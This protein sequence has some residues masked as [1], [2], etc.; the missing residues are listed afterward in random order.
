M[1]KQKY[2]S[3]GLMLLIGIATALGGR[4]YQMGT[5]GRMGPGYYPFLLGLVMVLIGAL[6][7]ATPESA[8]EALHD[9]QRTSFFDTARSHARPWLATI[10]GMVLFIVLG[11]YGGLAVATF[12]M[13]FL[14]AWG[15]HNNSLKACFWLAVAVTAFA[16]IVFHFG[17]QMQFPL[18][19]WG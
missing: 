6:I 19:T 13:V 2:L 5:L 15:D 16:V 3:G 9:Q 17:M 18:F 4:E 1:L 8:E 11:K 14:T 7:I 12:G 10:G